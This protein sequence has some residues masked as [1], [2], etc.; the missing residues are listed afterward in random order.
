MKQLP[1]NLASQVE[2]THAMNLMLRFLLLGLAPQLL[3]SGLNLLN[4]SKTALTV[5]M[6]F[7]L[8]KLNSDIFYDQLA[9]QQ[10]LQSQ[11]IIQSQ[12]SQLLHLR[13]KAECQPLL[14]LLTDM[15]S[16]L[17]MDQFL[18]MIQLKIDILSTQTPSR[19]MLMH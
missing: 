7:L 14:K 4:L 2:Q 9:R 11:Q 6:A 8:K 16:E 1:E 10:I 5:L 3:Q 17:V 18:V 15:L 19:I 12:L 13:L